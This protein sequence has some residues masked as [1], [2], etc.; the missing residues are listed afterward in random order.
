MFEFHG[1]VSIRADDTDD[2]DCGMLADRQHIVADA[3]EAKARALA[4]CSGIFTVH[5]NLNGEDHLIA[6]GS[7][8]HRQEDV[9]EL[10]RWIAKH[11]PHSYG[12]LHVRDDE[13]IREEYRNAFRVFAV[14]RGTFVE[15]TEALLS[16][17]IPKIEVPFEQ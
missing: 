5:R 10:F 8:N 16:P 9:I 12:L 14:A 15:A 13:D 2:P 3:L 7:A 4:W 11:Q 6:T 17:C 1:W